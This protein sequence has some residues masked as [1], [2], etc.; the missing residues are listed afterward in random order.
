MD[1]AGVGRVL[2]KRSPRATR[3]RIFLSGPDAVRV[4]VPSGA[5]FLR[6]AAFVASKRG[7][8]AQKAAQLRSTRVLDPGSILDEKGARERLLRRLDTL[9]RRYGLPFHRAFVRNQKTRWASCSAKNNIS[10]NIRLV[11]LP[12]GLMDY[13]ILHELVH[14]RIK[15]HGPGFWEMLEG[16]MSDAKARDHQLRGFRLG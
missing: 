1:V 13:V 16:L 6:A 2:L 10:L 3:I 15:D 5:S 12:E 4:T 9:S 11:L 14:T 8:I 7:W